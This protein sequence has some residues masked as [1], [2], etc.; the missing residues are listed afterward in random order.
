MSLI[1]GQWSASVTV[2]LVFE[3]VLYW[4]VL[5]CYIWLAIKSHH[6][7]ADFSFIFLIVNIYKEL[8]QTLLLESLIDICL[9]M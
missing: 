1:P 9:E 6:D 8:L 4:L 2:M 3:T 7:F 5:T